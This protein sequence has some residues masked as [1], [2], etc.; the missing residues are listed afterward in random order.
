[1]L[2]RNLAKKILENGGS[3]IPLIIDPKDSK[4]LGLMNPSILVEQTK[5]LLNLRNINYTLYHC[6]G[7]QLFNNRWGPLSYLHPENDMHLRTWNYMCELN[8]ETLEIQRYWLTDTKDFDKEPLWDFV[9]LEDARLF[10]WE[11]KLFQC[12]V[13]RDTTPNGVGRMELTELLEIEDSELTEG[14]S[15][16]KEI[17]RTRI[18]PPG[19][20]TYCE[21]NWMPVLDMPWHFVKWTNPTQV[22][23]VNP[24]TGQSETVFLGKSVIP[25]VRDFRGGSQVIPWRDY[26]ICLLHEVNL[27]NNKL[28][29]KDATYWH[30]FIVWDKNWNIVSMSEPFSFMDGEIEFG[31]GMA[32][33]RGDLLVTFGFQD[34]AAFILRIPE[35]MIEEVLGMKKRNFDWGIIE[36][37]NW[38]K[39]TIIKEIYNENVYEKHFPV[40]ENDIVVDIG[41]SVGPFVNKIITKR[42]KKVFALEPDDKFFP[43]LLKNTK[44]LNNVFCINK[45]IWNKNG[46]V[47]LKGLYNEHSNL[48][49][50]GN[51]Y[52]NVITFKKLLETYNIPSIDFLKIDCE[53]GEYNVF[54]EENLPWIKHNIKKISGEFHLSTQELLSK[55]LLFRDNVLVHF[56]NVRIETM[57]G[58][59]ITHTLHEN[60]F[61]TNTEI[62]I[63]IDN[64]EKADDKPPV[65]IMYKKEIKGLDKKMEGPSYNEIIENEPDKTPPIIQKLKDIRK[66]KWQ[67]VSWPSLEITTNLPKK[68]CVNDCVFCPQRVINNKYKGKASLTL[69]EFKT[70]ISSV[71]KEV[72]IIFSGFS[73]P[74]TNKECTNMILYAHEKGHKLA[75]FTTGIGMS[76]EDF[77]KIKHVPFSI[78]AEDAKLSSKGEPMLNGGFTLHLPD[79]ENYAK[80][81]ISQKYIQLLEHIKENHS[82]IKGFRVVCMGTIHDKV[83]H[84]FE[85]ALPIDIWSRANNVNKEMN[86]KPELKELENKGLWKS[87][88]WGEELMTCGITENVYHNVL[89]P[90]GDVVIC[91]MDY[92]LEYPLGNL[93]TQQY[94]DI[95]P[96]YNAT[97][98]LCRF[99]ENGTKIIEK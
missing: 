96:E 86:L 69:D 99:C 18:E 83:K 90:N 50:S 49:H 31:C 67:N 92:D 12:G 48:T 73:E 35:S 22:V 68:G 79:N 2:N 58:I 47:Q 91:C 51:R 25:N 76:V 57:S 23:K 29:Q 62:M 54:T 15:K 75:L 77:E 64:R 45:G 38:F 34:N 4:G 14:K 37:D 81:P 5:I 13:R 87:V 46:N 74:Y 95:I 44:H 32:F 3:I 28:Q 30:R 24:K 10:R 84:I 60:E 17:S 52:A 6:E 40:E 11:G 9:G 88:Y 33:Y 1:M 70:A 80:H 98:N 65:K 21:K 61:A 39:S 94:E 71:P 97:F 53:G 66:K 59:D 56:S 41:A 55:F 82:E 43:T 19:A 93:L 20:S 85:S 7:Q 63:Y 16:Y 36:N 8:P 42:P 27:F 72:A 89:L 26:R 78:G